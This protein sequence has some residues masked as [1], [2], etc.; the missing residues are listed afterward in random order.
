MKTECSHIHKTRRGTH[1]KGEKKFTTNCSQPTEEISHISIDSSLKASF[2]GEH[3][4]DNN[5]RDKVKKT[6][7]RSFNRTKQDSMDVQRILNKR[8]RDMIDIIKSYSSIK[9]NSGWSITMS[10]NGR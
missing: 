1:N 6:F 9:N 3:R 5:G 8:E 7:N 10:R 4:Y 2:C